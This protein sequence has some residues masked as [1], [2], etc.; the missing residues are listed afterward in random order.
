MPYPSNARAVCR[1]GK[2]NDG[3][4]TDSVKPPGIPKRGLNQDH[5]GQPG[6]IPYPVVVGG[7]DAKCIFSRIE[8]RI[9]CEPT[10]CRDPVLVEPFE[11][12]RVPVLLRRRQV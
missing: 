3:Q 12:I 9:C 2:C 8:V 6:V 11:L 10:L 1:P 4:G 5:N 7:P